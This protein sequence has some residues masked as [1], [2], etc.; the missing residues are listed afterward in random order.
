MNVII[1]LFA[2]LIL[3]L[4]MLTVFS[5]V[6]ISNALDKKNIHLDLFA[7]TFKIGKKTKGK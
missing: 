3:A 1:V 7:F 4:I 2:A 5:L 6:L